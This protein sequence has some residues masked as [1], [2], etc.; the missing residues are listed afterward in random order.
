MPARTRSNDCMAEHGGFE[1]NLQ[2]LRVVDELEQ[3]YPQFDGL[4]LSF[5]TREGI[6]KHCS[7]ANAERIE[8]AEPGGVAR[9]FLRPHP[10]EPRSAAVQPGRRD[11]LQRARHRRRRALGPDRA[12]S[13]LSEVDLFDRYRREALAEHPQLQGRRVL[14]ETIRRMLS[15]QVYDVI[16]AT[17]RRARARPRRPTPTPCARAPPLVLFSDADARAV[18]R[19]QALPVRAICTGI[20]SVDAD[21]RRGRSRW[22]ANCSRPTSASRSEM[23][24]AYRAARSDRQ[25]AVADYIAGMTDRFAMREHERLTGRR[26]TDMSRSG[27]QGACAA[28][29]RPRWPWSLAGV[30]AA[31]HL[32]KL[33]P[34]VPALQATLGIGLVEAG[35]LLSLVQVAGMTL[36]L[37]GRACGGHDRAAPQHAGGPGRGHRCQRAGGAGRELGPGTTPVPLLLAL[38]ALEGMGF[39]LAVMPGPGPDPRLVAAERREDGARPVGRLHAAWRGAG[40]AARAG[41]DRVGRLAGLVVGAVAGLGWQRLLWVALGVPADTRH[42]GARGALP[43]RWSDAPARHRRRARA[44]DAGAGLRGLLIAVDGGDRL[45]ACRSMPRPASPAA[46]NAAL[47]ALAAA[48]NIVGN[49]AGGRLL[50]HGVAPE[51]LLRWGFVAMALGSVAAFAQVGQAARC[52]EPAAR[53]ALCSRCACSRSAAAWCRPRSSCWPSGSRRGRPPYRRRWG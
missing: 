27:S 25:R 16:D 10:A 28:F 31:L 34:A 48:M 4:N 18:D 50:Q 5:E 14:Y 40:A 17:P 15:A 38:R 45:S 8:A 39:L 12:S 47:T 1:H 35:F 22:C 26:W 3:R 43:E 19:A 52:R 51:R 2:S 46:W 29:R 37:A 36:G 30:S 42:H 32:G 21:H 33:P 9:R 7:R 44:L 23:P 24:A 11:R 20:R 13:S 49:V 41:A 53:A 6:L